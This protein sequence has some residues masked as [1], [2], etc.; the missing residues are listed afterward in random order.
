[1]E[2]LETEHKEILE[3]IEAAHRAE[4]EELERRHDTLQ[5]QLTHAQALHTEAEQRLVQIEI[6]EKELQQ[7]LE[8]T[9]VEM[10]KMNDTRKKME[11]ASV[12]LEDHEREIA[13]GRRLAQV[14]DDLQTKCERLERDATEH[15]EQLRTLRDAH[16]QAETQWKEVIEKVRQGAI[17]AE[18]IAKERFEIEVRDI[19]INAER[20]LGTLEEKTS[21]MLASERTIVDLKSEL[22]KESARSEQEI[23]RLQNLVETYRSQ[24]ED[25]QKR[26]LE[27]HKT[28][29]D[30]IRDRDEKA[31][32]QQI[33]ETRE[34]S[35]LQAKY[36]EM[37]RTQESRTTELRD[38]KRRLEENEEISSENKKDQGGATGDGVGLCSSPKRKAPARDSRGELPPRSRPTEEG[39]PDH[40]RRTRG[41]TC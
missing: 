3:R 36:Q 34:Q 24:S 30:D 29:I 8:H 28:M 19:R 41:T 9:Q 10:E 27:M 32:E 35:E 40:G 11:A 38:L 22:S 18:T 2:R 6:Q 1:M 25:A 16:T 14:R 17:E 26:V 23:T 5:A 15:A 37:I 12:S 7:R 39:K 33:K 4:I 31:R 13:E 20:N 21:Q